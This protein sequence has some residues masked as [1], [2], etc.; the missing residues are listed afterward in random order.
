MDKVKAKLMV[1]LKAD[2]VVVAEAEDSMLWAAVLAAINTGTAFQTASTAIPSIVERDTSMVSNTGKMH[3]PPHHGTEPVE[4]FAKEVGVDATVLIG[5]IDPMLADPFL[6]LDSHH[7]EAMR[8]QLPLRGPNS[9]G[10]IVVSATLLC[11]W[12]KHNGMGG[13]SKA[14]AQ[15]VL[16]TIGLRDNNPGRNLE[17]PPWLQTRPGGQILINPSQVS[18]AIALARCF[19]TQ[20]WSAW[21]S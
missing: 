16:Q 20:D 10:P 21:K 15:S 3:A 9:I 4:R 8:K 13:V 14:Q 7:W 1:V 6:H 18:K 12:S 11:L 19:C 17:G 2:D 5:A